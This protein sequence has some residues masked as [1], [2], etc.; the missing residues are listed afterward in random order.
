[1]SVEAWN[2][3]RCIPASS[4]HHWALVSGSGWDSGFFE[5]LLGLVVV[6]FAALVRH[7]VL[8]WCGCPALWSYIREG[9]TPHSLRHAFV[10]ALLGRGVPITDAAQWVGH[11]DINVTYA[12]YG[13]LVPNAA[14][15]P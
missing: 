14:D 7:R 13:H 11:K 8:Q 15:V 6:F 2:R 3:A 12:I 1:V 9:F 4:R 5:E 10:S